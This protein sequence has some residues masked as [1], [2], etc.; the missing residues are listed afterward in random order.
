[1]A[2]GQSLIRYVMGSTIAGLVLAGLLGCSNC[3]GESEGPKATGRILFCK[4]GDKQLFAMRPDGSQ[5]EKLSVGLRCIFWSRD[6]RHAARLDGDTLC[7]L[8]G[9]R[10]E[11][12]PR[13]S[14]SSN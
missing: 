7:L 2:S 9:G 12:T 3:L 13:D 11:P 8:R 10:W 4:Q 1:M 14:N 6:F 5:V